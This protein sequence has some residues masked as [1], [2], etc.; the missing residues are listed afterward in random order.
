MPLQVSARDSR[1]SLASRGRTP[2]LAV[3]ACSGALALP[4]GLELPRA[5]RQDFRGDAKSV[6]LVD[7]LS[8]PAQR[9]LL[10]G[11]GKR[12]R[13]D[14]ESLRR[15]AATAVKKA[16]TLELAGLTVWLEHGLAK[17]VGAER[18]GRAL[19][20]GVLLGAYAYRE[21]KSKP[22]RAALRRAE[23]HGPGSAFRSGARAGIVRAAACAFARDLQN[24]PGNRM[25]PRA[26]AE[27]ARKL[28]RRSRRIRC[29]VLDERALRALGMGALLSVAR[30]SAEPPRFVHLV[31]R[32][33]GRNRGRVALVGKGLTFDAGG[34]SL[35]PA[36]KMEEMKFDM[37]GGAAVLGVFHALAEVDVPYEVHGLVP[38]S[39]NLPDG[40]ANKPGDVVTAMDGTTIEVLNTDAE[41]RLILADALAYCREKVQPDVIVDLATLTGAVVIA[42]GHELSGLF[43]TS[44]RLR[45]ELTAAGRE[46][47]EALW[48]LPLLDVHKEQ[49]K[50]TVADLRNI[51]D[52][53]HGNGASAG[54]AF[55][56][57]F[58]G[59]TEWAHLDIAGTAWGGSNREWVGG[60][61]GSGVGVR[62]LLEWLETR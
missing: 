26:L 15:A 22:K 52:P 57:H 5:A 42:L 55:L 2:L 50:G 49:M 23:L 14:A 6:R 30:G 11:L 4:A 10:I 17:R 39:E 3:P 32:P 8:G 36:A 45:D 44:E 16:Q 47:G 33:R 60:P 46:V 9:V 58:V 35:K 19:A 24:A 41:G 53:G 56:S 27:A 20:E 62:L 29:R 40:R 48:P 25:T 7:P 37:S 51:N 43:A 34:I 38:C 18:A 31:Y 54:A 12:E 21:H 61:G 1:S 28:A 13:L 59:S